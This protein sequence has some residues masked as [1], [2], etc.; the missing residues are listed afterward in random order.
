MELSLVERV[1]ASW[2]VHALV[3]KMWLHARRIDFT[4]RV[5]VML[6]AP[7]SIYYGL[8]TYKTCMH[9]YRNK[10]K[11]PQPKF[12]SLPLF[13]KCA[14]GPKQEENSPTPIPL[15][16]PLPSP[17]TGSQ[18]QIRTKFHNPSSPPYSLPSPHIGKP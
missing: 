6:S 10:K 5:V 7:F 14:H 3:C 9:I 15:P 8:C 4:N 17:H 13:S 2:P 11:F 1:H 16:I 12:L 18:P